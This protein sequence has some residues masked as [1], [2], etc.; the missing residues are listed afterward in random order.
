MADYVLGVEITGDAS[1][2]QKAA[3]EAESLLQSI[4]KEAEQSAKTA[5][6]AAHPR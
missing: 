6:S 1:G 4:S 2:L 5:E 3:K